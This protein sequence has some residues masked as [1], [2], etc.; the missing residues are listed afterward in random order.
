[1]TLV[2]NG[3][4]PDWPI[5]VLADVEVEIVELSA[6]TTLLEVDTGLNLCIEMRSPPADV[7]TDATLPVETMFD[8][9]LD[10]LSVASPAEEPR[11]FTV[12]ETYSAN[13]EGVSVNVSSDASCVDE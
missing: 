11:V 10:E 9:E 2:P 4:Y 5:S 13:V 6:S 1:M 12:I 7:S 3:E 8:P